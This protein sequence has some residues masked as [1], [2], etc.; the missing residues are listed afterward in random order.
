MSF[1]AASLLVAA[2]SLS[3]AQAVPPKAS[4]FSDKSFGDGGGYKHPD[5]EVG[6][7]IEQAPTNP[8]PAPRRETAAIPSKVVPEQKPVAPEASRPRPRPFAPAA[9]AAAAAAA[10]KSAAKTASKPAA[11]PAAAP[12][13]GTPLRAQADVA[14]VAEDAASEEARRDYETRLLGAGPG[15]ES[16]RPGLDG[17]RASAPAPEPRP[18][19]ALPASATEE[20]MLFVSLELDPKEAGSLRDAVAGLGAAA[21]F[22]PD[23][24]FSALAAEGGRTRISG[25]LPASRLGDAI[26]RRGVTRV[27]VERG[28][29]PADDA[30]L[31]GDFL[32]RLRVSDPA[33]SEETIAESVRGLTN[34]TGFKL[35]RVYGVESVPE[36]GATALVSGS[37]PLSQ[38]S[39]A[40]AMPGVLQVN[41]SLP[42]A[43]TSA[44]PAEA[45]AREGFLKFVVNRGLWLV[46]LTILLALP[47]VG[48]AVRSALA[49]FVPYR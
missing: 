13:P 23:P 40:L 46:L 34:S 1:L 6:E 14:G 41:A 37:M 48:G 44:A 19:T 16:S 25:W 8:D 21:A 5:A 10:P 26:T 27:S 33:R 31:T 12:K 4:P 15:A 42:S 22:R 20:G 49:V 9:P 38:L 47:T 2:A 45:P 30:R 28:A 36:G 29:R 24:R 7:Y 43:E 32:V 35:N 11:A 17:G 18:E 39:R 3:T